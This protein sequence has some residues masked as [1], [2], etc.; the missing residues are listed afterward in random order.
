MRL[1][2]SFLFLVTTVI[3]AQPALR[4]GEILTFRVGWGLFQGAGEIKILA[5]SVPATVGPPQLR[6]TTTTATRGFARALY[7]FEARADALFDAQTGRLL[8][9]TESTKASSRETR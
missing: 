4:D 3:S 8:T 2:A 9:N 7:T 5:E 6:V 1:L